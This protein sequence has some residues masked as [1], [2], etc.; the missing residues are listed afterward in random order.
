LFYSAMHLVHAEFDRRELPDGMRHPERHS[1]KNGFDYG[2]NDV[3]QECFPP[4]LSAFY[5]QLSTGAYIA[6]YAAD[7]PRGDC[8]RFWDAYAR[9][10]QG[11]RRD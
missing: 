10:D 8:A 3:V 4:R 6:R 7:P 1:G 2:T 11:L 5:R 9:L